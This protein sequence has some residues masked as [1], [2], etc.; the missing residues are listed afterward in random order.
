MELYIIMVL[1]AAMQMYGAHLNDVHIAVLD[2]Q[3]LE[4]GCPFLLT[5]GLV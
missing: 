1:H 4:E 5:G 2:A 3:I